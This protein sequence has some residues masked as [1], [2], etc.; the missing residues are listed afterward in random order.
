MAGEAVPKETVLFRHSSPFNS[1]V[2]LSVAKIDKENYNPD[3]ISKPGK[4]A[5]NSFEGA[6]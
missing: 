6:D 4:R 2:C 5:M 3:C 1:I